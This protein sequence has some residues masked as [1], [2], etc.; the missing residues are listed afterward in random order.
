MQTNTSRGMQTME[1][2]L[3]DLALRR[4]VNVED[5]LSRSSRPDQLIG[6]LERSGMPVEQLSRTAAPTAQPAGGLRTAG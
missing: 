4:V 6:I 2:A 5:A 1:Q 3:A